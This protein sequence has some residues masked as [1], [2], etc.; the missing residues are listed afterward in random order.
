MFSVIASLKTFVTHYNE[1]AAHW[2]SAQSPEFA[3]S[4]LT[5]I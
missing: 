3:V 5:L 2:N 4:F 1:S